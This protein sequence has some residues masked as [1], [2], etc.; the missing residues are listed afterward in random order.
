MIKEL[1]GKYEGQD[2]Y[3]YTLDNGIIK[4]CILNYSS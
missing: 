3:R 1:F 2:V 4:M